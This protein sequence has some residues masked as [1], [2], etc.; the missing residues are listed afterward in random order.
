MIMF[1]NYRIIKLE[2][3]SAKTSAKTYEQGFADGYEARKAELP[4]QECV[5]CKQREVNFDDVPDW[6]DDKSEK[7]QDIVGANGPTGEHYDYDD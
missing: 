7:R 5:Y 1:W 2:E 4:I 3:T 6:G